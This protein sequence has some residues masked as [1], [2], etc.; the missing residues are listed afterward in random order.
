[1]FFEYI[2]FFCFH[3]WCFLSFLFH[4]F[5]FFCLCVCVFSCCFVSLGFGI[6]VFSRFLSCLIYF[7]TL[8]KGVLRFLEITLL[9]GFL[10]LVYLP[11]LRL[12]WFERQRC[13]HN[14]EQVRLFIGKKKNRF[15]LEGGWVFDCEGIVSMRCFPFVI[16]KLLLD[17]SSVQTLQAFWRTLSTWLKSALLT[18]PFAQCVLYEL[19]WEE[20]DSDAKRKTMLSS[21]GEETRTREVLWTQC[22]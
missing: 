18:N 10:A 9:L 5:L 11:R 15:G 16:F 14:I 8:L 22:Q 12:S 13:F 21:L 2:L 20:W 7:W 6:M 1:M 19:C 17:S 4:L 3:I